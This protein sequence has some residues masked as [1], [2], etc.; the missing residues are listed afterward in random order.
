MNPIGIAGLER[1]TRAA[2]PPCVSIFVPPSPVA[3]QTRAERLMLRSA[4]EAADTELTTLGVQKRGR[5]ELLAPGRAL[6]ARPDR[7]PLPGHGIA[8]FLWRGGSRSIETQ[9]PSEP[10]VVVGDRLHVRPLL[11]RAVAEDRFILASIREHGVRLFS[12]DRDG[13]APMP[14]DDVPQELREVVGYDHRPANLQ[15][16]SQGPRSGAVTRT[17]VFHGQGAG[18]DDRADE[19]AQYLRAVDRALVLALRGTNCPVVLA[20]AEPVATAFRR[21]SK[22][23]G[24]LDTGIPQ[25]AAP[26]Q[27]AALHARA[28]PLVRDKLGGTA[29]RALDQ[30]RQGLGTGRVIQQPD[31][32]VLAAGEGRI[33]HLLCA[34]GRNLWAAPRTPGKPHSVRGAGDL[35]MVDVASVETLRHGGEVYFVQ[36]ESLPTD[37]SPFAAVLRKP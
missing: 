17:A 19:R 30:V 34:S 35:D 37:D 26:G 2:I 28:W 24:L 11:E 31:A 13:I 22:I 23:P 6:V 36:G 29:R 25:A 3:E 27:E 4:L 10:L 8:L 5:E 14:A 33:S 15:M 20:A 7:E 1:L 21:V 18:V 12:G 9:T 32:V 16:H